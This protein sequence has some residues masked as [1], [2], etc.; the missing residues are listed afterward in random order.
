MAPT[1]KQ[2]A[3]MVELLSEHEQSLIFELVSRLIPDDIATPEDI[4]DIKQARAD[5]ANGETVRLEDLNLN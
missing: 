5:Y 1:V 4:A 3:D 2:I